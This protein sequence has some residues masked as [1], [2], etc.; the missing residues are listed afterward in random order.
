MYLAVEESLE[1]R[2][3]MEGEVEGR[4][5]REEGDKDE[6]GEDKMEEIS[7]PLDILS[8]HS[9]PIYTQNIHKIMKWLK[10]SINMMSGMR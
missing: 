9:N 4:W 2:W 8:L 6:E 5:E 3:V 7:I 1:G 10:E